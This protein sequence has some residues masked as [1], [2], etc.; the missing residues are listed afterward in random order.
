MKI[1][2]PAKPIHTS[3]IDGDRLTITIPVRKNW[4]LIGWFSICLI[5][6]L[7]TFF[8]VMFVPLILSFNQ[9]VSTSPTGFIGIIFI[10]FVIFGPL[11]YIILALLWRFFGEEIITVD[12]QHL[13]IN[14]KL[15]FTNREKAYLIKEVSSF[16]IFHENRIF[17]S[18]TGMLKEGFGTKG[19]ISFDYGAKTIPFGNEVDPAEGKMVIQE[20]EDWLAGRN[21]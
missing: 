16:D 8:P 5:F 15:L 12:Q 13:I 3:E 4:L 10:T 20:I 11:I 17:R 9:E 18:P 7:L 1:V 2:E 6:F 21:E 19:S 14:K